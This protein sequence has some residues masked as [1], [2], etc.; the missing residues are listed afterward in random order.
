MTFKELLNDEKT[1]REIK[2][3]LKASDAKTDS[4]SIAVLIEEAK[5]HG[6]DVTENEIRLYLVSKMEL[7]EDEMANLAGGAQCTSD[8]AEYADVC[9]FAETCF[10]TFLHPDGT[11]EHLNRCWSDY[12]CFSGDH[13]IDME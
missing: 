9:W 4:E 3:A 11:C 13:Q 1:A 12:C 2:E 7:S 6:V 8:Y 10:A 5:K